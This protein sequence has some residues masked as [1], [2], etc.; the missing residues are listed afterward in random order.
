M[1]ERARG[2]GRTTPV[3]AAFLTLTLSA[4]VS[5]AVVFAS[6]GALGAAFE[7]DT[8]AA[9]AALSAIVV[10]VSAA[11]RPRRPWQR[12]TETPQ[13]WLLREGLS[14]A[15]RNGTALG[16][17]AATRIGFWLWWTLPPLV[18]ASG[19]PTV[20][21]ATGAC[22]GAT[23]LG[24]SSLIALYASATER[25]PLL[26]IGALRPVLDAVSDVSTLAVAT[27]VVTQTLST[28]GHG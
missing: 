19:R 23:R 3:V 16:A 6:V 20:G 7:P 28:L 4:A 24:A 10:A 26:E 2:I 9:L 25:D 1:A 12:D 11:A 21:L 15:I 13:R 5:G 8:R 27:V 17:G 18:F 22:Y 14:V